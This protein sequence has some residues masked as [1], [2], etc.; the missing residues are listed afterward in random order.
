MSRL[1]IATRSTCDW[2]S[3]LGDPELHWK[4]RASAMETALSWAK[5]DSSPAGL[6]EPIATL[7]HKS[8]LGESKLLLAVAE[9][10]VPLAGKGGDSQ[11]DVWALVQCALGMVSLAVEA[12]A[13]ETFG[14]SNELLAAWLES[15]GSNGSKANRELRWSHVQR[16]LPAGPS[17]AY[18]AVPFQILQRCAAAVIEARR[19][20]LKHAAFVVQSF[21]APDKSFLLFSEFRKAAGAPAARDVVSLVEVG[22]IRLGLGWADCQFATDAE[23]AA[24][25]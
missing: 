12:K 9:H 10:K 16:N 14:T 1:H 21:G 19:F 3:R 5:A 24:V 18:D 25:T 7:F 13:K 4:R 20:R 22:D 23:I 17:G 11:C 2:R 6:P 15:G 8:E